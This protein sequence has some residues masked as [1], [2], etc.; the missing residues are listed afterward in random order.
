MA[1]LLTKGVATTNAEN[2]RI[3]VSF[4]LKAATSTFTWVDHR[5]LLLRCRCSSGSWVHRSS[6]N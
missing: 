4:A 3:A 1:R 5:G 6:D 2:A